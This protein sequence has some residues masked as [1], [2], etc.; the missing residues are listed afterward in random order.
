MNAGN[1]VILNND[2]ISKPIDHID[3]VLS[4]GAIGTL[5][6][7]NEDKCNVSFNIN[8]SISILVWI[9]EKDIADI[10]E[11]IKETFI[12]KLFSYFKQR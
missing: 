3:I 10:S 4:H 8:K 11:P 9:D 12:H 1:S 5:I 6:A 7:R 2:F